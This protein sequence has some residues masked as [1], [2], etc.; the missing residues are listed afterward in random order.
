[1][2][3]RSTESA[4]TAMTVTVLPSPVWMSWKPRKCWLVRVSDEASRCH[5]TSRRGAFGSAAWTQTVL[6]GGGSGVPL[7]V[8][9]DGELDAPD[10]AEVDGVD[11]AL[12]LG[13][14]DGA[15]VGAPVGVDGG[16]EG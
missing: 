2:S 4:W 12:E 7:N 3:V 6:G 1:M 8:I 15:E 13:L 16:V 11:G 10:G 14:D 9:P 5:S